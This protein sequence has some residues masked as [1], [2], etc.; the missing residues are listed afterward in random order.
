M[1]SAMTPGIPRVVFLD[2][3]H[4]LHQVGPDVGDLGEDAARDAQ[5][6]RAQRLADGE[7]EEA[8]AGHV[9]GHEEQDAEHEQELDRDEHHADAHARAER[10]GVDRE[11]LAGEA[12][13][14][15]ARVGEGV[16]ADAVPRHA[17]AAG[18]ADEA[19]QQHDR[20]LRRREA[21]QREV[22]HDDGADEG[23]QHQQELALLHQVRLAGD[24]DQLRHLGHGLVHRQLLH[25]AVRPEAEQQAQ[26]ADH[27]ARQQD[28]VPGEA[29]EV[30]LIEV[31]EEKVHLPAGTMLLRREQRNEG[32]K[33]S[34]R[35]QHEQRNETSTHGVHS[36]HLGYL[37]GC[38]TS[39]RRERHGRDRPPRAPE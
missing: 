39:R 17:V 11:A 1:Q 35:E 31:R 16:D 2:L 26:H 5:H 4:H 12:G 9:T 15:R 21:R 37:L 33:E 18:H 22:R 27:Q 20:D 29:Q 36:G 25:G 38:R 6:R 34:A 14:R 30:A 28:L 23:E 3:E 10:D 13:E 32:G 19:E 7:A 24:V 8:G